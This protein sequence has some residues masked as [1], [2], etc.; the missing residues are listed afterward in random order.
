MRILGNITGIVDC[1]GAVNVDATGGPM[2]N[3]LRSS[4]I[5]GS[6]AKTVLVRDTQ[7]LTYD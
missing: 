3:G 7:D 6:P 5:L 4:A 2:I 1:P